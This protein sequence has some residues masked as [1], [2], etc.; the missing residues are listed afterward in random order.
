[1]RE[2]ITT[3]WGM[4]TRLLGALVLIALGLVVVGFFF[5]VL[6]W[7]AIGLAIGLFLLAFA[8]LLEG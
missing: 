4:A 3:T 2:I 1:M 6:G 8:S 7:W 5:A